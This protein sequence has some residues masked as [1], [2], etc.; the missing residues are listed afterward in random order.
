MSMENEIRESLATAADLVAL[1]T[2]LAGEP[3]EMT[4]DQFLD[5]VVLPLLNAQ[6]QAILKLARE[7]DGI[8]YRTRNQ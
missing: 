7:V 6:Q 4:G 5:R 3:I 1:E 2:V 8:N